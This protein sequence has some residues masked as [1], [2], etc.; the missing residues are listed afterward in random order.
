M[1]ILSELKRI[2]GI[3]FPVPSQ[4]D[5]DQ[6]R[7]DEIIKG[8][9]LVEVEKFLKDNSLWP[10]RISGNTGRFEHRRAHVPWVGVHSP[11]IDSKSLE[12]VYLTILINSDGNGFALSVQRG[13]EGRTDMQIR[14]AIARLRV[15]FGEPPKGFF[16]KNLADIVSSRFNSS[17]RSRKYQLSN[18]VGKEYLF[19]ATFDEKSF[20]K[21]FFSIVEHYSKWIDV[22]WEAEDISIEEEFD[23]EESVHKSISTK[24][25]PPDLISLSSKDLLEKGDLEALAELQRRADRGSTSKALYRALNELKGKLL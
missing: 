8:S 14:S 2:Q 20:E 22:H 6:K 17:D 13:V 19:S 21:E 1:S 18:V 16:N 10:F 3:N 9:L 24:S 12:G 23:L 4:N 5:E 15:E 25:S 7:L 11:F